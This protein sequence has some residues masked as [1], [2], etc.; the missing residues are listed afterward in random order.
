MLHLHRS[1]STRP[2]VVAKHVVGKMRRFIGFLL[3]WLGNTRHL[4]FDR[5]TTSRC[6]LVLEYIICDSVIWDHGFL[7][8]FMLHSPRGYVVVSISR[9]VIDVATCLRALLLGSAVATPK[10]RQV[11]PKDILYSGYMIQMTV[12]H[13][14]EVFDIF[15]MAFIYLGPSVGANDGSWLAFFAPSHCIFVREVLATNVQTGI[16]QYYTGIV[17]P[18]L[19]RMSNLGELNQQMVKITSGKDSVMVNPRFKEISLR[20]LPRLFPRLIP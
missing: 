3:L 17:E 13:I 7:P 8:F 18:T 11:F 15:E 20:G 6:S 1:Q 19:R 5:S 4:D 9:R 12:C 16:S 2:L 10:F 14:S